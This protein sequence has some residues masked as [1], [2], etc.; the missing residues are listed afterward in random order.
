MNQTFDEATK[1]QKQ[2]LDASDDLVK[3]QMDAELVRQELT[4][5]E[6][7]L[8][9][10]RNLIYVEQ[11]GLGKTGIMTAGDAKSREIQLE[12]YLRMQPEYADQ[13]G[14]IKDKEAKEVNAKITAQGA[15]V[16]FDA[17]K[18]VA[19]ITVRKLDFETQLLASE[20]QVKLIEAAKIKITK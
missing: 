20:T 14:R 7:E 11:I 6:R 4:G 12:N 2:L 8:E 5:L 15:R 13:V 18:S 17:L 16:K 10:T 3:A 9:A 1:I 19:E